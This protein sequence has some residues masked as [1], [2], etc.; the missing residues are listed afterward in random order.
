M[1][2]E[3][4]FLQDKNKDSFLKKLLNKLRTELMKQFLKKRMKNILKM[5]KRA[6]LF[7]NFGKK[8]VFDIKFT[9]CSGYNLTKNNRNYI[10]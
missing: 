1:W 2:G 3:N 10:I 6:D 9:I 4:M 5:A 8:Q 7:R